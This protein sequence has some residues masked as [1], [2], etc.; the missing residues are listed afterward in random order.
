M[1]NHVDRKGLIEQT[2]HRAENAADG[3]SGNIG[4]DPYAVSCLSSSHIQHM[5]VRSCLSAGTCA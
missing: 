2:V 1:Q 3:S 4:A 5:D